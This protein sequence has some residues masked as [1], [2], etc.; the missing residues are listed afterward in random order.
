MRKEAI[1][2]Q[3][4][5]A[6][7]IIETGTTVH[8]AFANAERFGSRSENLRR[9]GL[10]PERRLILYGTNHG[11]S[12]RDEVEVVKRVAEWVEN[13]ELGRRAANFGFAYTRRRSPAFMRFPADA[14]R[15][16]AS[17]RVFVEFPPVRDNEHAVAVAEKRSGTS[18]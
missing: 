6:E 9:L 7:R 12:F 13:D 1:D 2:L 16:L 5:P 3:G 10:D 4:I 15:K 11:G 18:G 14:Y 8:D 17:K